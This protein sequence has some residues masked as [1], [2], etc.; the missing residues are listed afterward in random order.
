MGNWVDMMA[1]AQDNCIR[2]PQGHNS[3]PTQV[4]QTWLT[5][6]SSQILYKCNLE[7]IITS[8]EVNTVILQLT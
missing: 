4:H 3:E 7:K 1:N 6:H 8:N 2:V 5:T